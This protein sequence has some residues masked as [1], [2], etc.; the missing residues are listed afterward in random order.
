MKTNLFIV[1][2]LSASSSFSQT[3]IIAHKSHAGSSETFFT[4]PSTNF[5][6]P[7][8]Q[9]I[10][11]KQINDTTYVRYEQPW[12]SEA[13]YVDTIYKGLRYGGVYY[14][15]P[16]SQR[17]ISHRQFEKDTAALSKKGTQQLENTPP[18][19]NETAQPE[20]P[21]KTKKKKNKSMLPWFLMLG[22]IGIIGTKRWLK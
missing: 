9:L 12:N 11:E 22:T 1:L 15:N 14:G 6:E 3:A 18:K 4:D 19:P 8:P 13:I 16:N 7:G 2:L 10:V 21:M 5:G 17:K 20:Q